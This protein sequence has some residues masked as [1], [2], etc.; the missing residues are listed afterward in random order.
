M[1]NTELLLAAHE[2]NR[3]RVTKLLDNGADIETQGYHGYTALLVAA[4]FGKTGV[5][6]VL[7]AR[8]ANT[9]AQD[10]RGR[11]ALHHVAGE[12]N[13]KVVHILVV[14]GNA[15]V[16]VRDHDG[17]TPLHSAVLGSNSGVKAIPKVIAILLAGGAEKEAKEYGGYSALELAIGPNCK[18]IEI[19]LE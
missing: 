4:V 18:E 3:E 15:D 17:N 10:T 11:T 8:G 6:T 14:R 5:M 13:W 7:L 12:G 9:S 1:S 2:G 19:L 16:E